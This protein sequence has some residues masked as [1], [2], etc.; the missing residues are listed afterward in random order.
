MIDGYEAS[1]KQRATVLVLCRA[2]AYMKNDI[3]QDSK[4]RNGESG[5]EYIRENQVQLN[6]INSRTPKV[7]DFSVSRMKLRLFN[8]NW[9]SETQS[10]TT[11]RLKI[12]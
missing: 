6:S 3:G 9:I 11:V 1:L 7:L 10:K 12:N 4:S 8:V 5:S 2:K